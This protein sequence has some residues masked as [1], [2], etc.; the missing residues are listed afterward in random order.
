MSRAQA[1]TLQSLGDIWRSRG[2]LMRVIG[3][4]AAVV[5]AYYSTVYGIRLTINEKADRQAVAQIDQRLTVI[6][7]LLRTDVARRGDLVQFRDIVQQRLTR[8]ETLLEPKT[9]ESR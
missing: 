5:A 2:P 9:Q 8:I 6:E 1:A 4:L 7:T 3:I